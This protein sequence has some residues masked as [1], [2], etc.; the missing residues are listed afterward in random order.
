MKKY[1]WVV[2]GLSLFLFSVIS[3]LVSKNMTTTFDLDIYKLITFSKSDFTINIFKT[4]T[5]LAGEYGILSVI[6]ISFILIKDKKY[7]ICIFL[8][9]FLV[10]LINY[11]T[12]NIFMRDRPFDLMIIEEDGY[13][14]PSGHS[15]VAVGFYGFIVYLI[16][17]SK[18]EKKYKYIFTLIILVLIICIGI[19][20]I[21]LGVHFPTD[22]LGGYLLSLAFVII[23]IYILEKKDVL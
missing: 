11:I 20:R 19:S 23:F 17:K 5:F 8:D 21:Y 9:G 1:R 14:F 2:F 6:V 22:V 10:V 12:K 3:Y 7:G 13:S 18:L 4:I 16:W 15:M